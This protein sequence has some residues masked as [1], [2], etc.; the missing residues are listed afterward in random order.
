MKKNALNEELT[1][2]LQILK[3]MLQALTIEL[4][5][6]LG[7]DHQIVNKLKNYILLIST[8]QEQEQVK[9]D[10]KKTIEALKTIKAFDEQELNQIQSTIKEASKTEFK[11]VIKQNKK[12]I[13]KIL[14]ETIK[15]G[16]PTFEEIKKEEQTENGIIYFLQELHK[17]LEEHGKSEK[18]IK[19]ILK[20]LVN[21]C[22]SLL[23]IIKEEEADVSNVLKEEKELSNI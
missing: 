9:Q 2:R 20:S 21:L 16:E 7:V 4:E 6:K 22:K 5:K 3:K 18:D 19:I 1:N 8:K 11:I 14:E 12:E 17:K 10:I 15:Y 23:K 13:I